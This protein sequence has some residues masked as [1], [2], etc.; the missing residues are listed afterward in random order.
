MVSAEIQS[1]KEPPWRIFHEEVFLFTTEALRTQREFFAYRE[2][3][4]GENSLSTCHNS[5][6]IDSRSKHFCLSV[7]PDKQKLFSVPSVSPW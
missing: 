2:V 4:I 6:E 5:M 1:I 7:S 3:P